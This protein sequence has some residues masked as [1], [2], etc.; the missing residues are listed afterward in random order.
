[1]AGGGSVTRNARSSV[2]HQLGER[3]KE[4]RCLYGMAE[5]IERTGETMDIL[6]QGVADL[7]PPSWQFPEVTA[8]RISF[9]DREYVTAGFRAGEWWQQADIVVAG[10][11]SGGVEV[12][13]TERMPDFD[14]GPFL[15]EERALIDAIAERIGRT[16]ER[17]DAAGELRRAHNQVQVERRALGEANIALRAVM[18]RIEA[19]KEEIKATMA[20]NVEE[21]LMPILHALE[22]EVPVAQSGYVE[23]LKGNLAEITSP[24][25]SRLAS[26]CLSL[27]PT[28]VQIC[29]MIRSGL[30]TKE[31]ARVRHISPATVCRH[32]E[33]IR[34]KF[35]LTNKG[36]NLVTYL[37]TVGES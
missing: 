3:V 6:L 12:H 10:E 37:Q 32:R 30:T 11:T 24:F 9:G 25:V 20:T 36:V 14:E 31:V 15:R 16:A 18:S 22:L 17:L 19:E 7:I 27:T 33:N 29:N 21:I 28:E 8:A 34:R 1:M 26:S 13:Y 5:L 23:L 35:D 2:E 4:L